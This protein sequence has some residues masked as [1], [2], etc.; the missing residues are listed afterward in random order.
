MPTEFT[1]QLYNPDLQVE[2]RRETGTFGTPHYDFSMPQDTF[3]Q[4]SGSMLDRTQHDPAASGVTPKI[5]FSFK[6]ESKLTKDMVLC[7]KGRSTDVVHKKK[8]KEPD[9]SIALFK[10]LREVTIYEPNLTRVEMEDPK[11]L[12]VVVLLAATI[13]KDVFYGAL[14]QAFNVNDEQRRRSSSTTDGKNGNILKKENRPIP[15]TLTQQPTAMM[16]GGL[17]PQASSQPGAQPR[18][19]TS[20]PITD[21]RT[22]WQLD[23]ETARLKAEAD[24]EAKEARRQEET[25]RREQSRRDDIESRRLM[26]QLEA[27]EKER[28]R[29]EKEVAKET[30]R[31]RKIYGNQ[32]QNLA[33]SPTVTAGQRPGA[34]SAP[35]PQGPF[36]QR[37]AAQPVHQRPGYPSHPQQSQRPAQAGPSR[38]VHAAPSSTPSG[39]SHHHTT[40][41]RPPQQSAPPAPQQGWAPP[42]QPQRPSHPQRNSFNAL[43]A[44]ASV[45]NMLS[46]T[47]HHAGKKS[48]WNLRGK[49]E[50]QN[51]LSKKTSSV[52]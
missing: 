27:E 20:E 36:P 50:E 41:L 47:S 42:S 43:N 15:G 8:S 51:R 38:M 39:S 46:S 34:H 18:R 16:S 2:V 7:M 25:R 13:I 9:I 4:P 1:I 6:R 12:E 49:S 45:S 24:A 32:A 26:K 5:N 31:L 10:A 3:R 40:G 21:P 22:Q 23:A 17:N 11:G 44:G 52:W 37:P 35:I 14:R 33:P 29:R 19:K 28:R 48:M 30:E